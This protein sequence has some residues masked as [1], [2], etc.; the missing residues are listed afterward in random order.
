MSGRSR[1][2]ACAA[3]VIV[4]ILGLL[5]VL[6]SSAQAA[7]IHPLLVAERLS[8]ERTP[9]SVA[10]NQATHHFYVVNWNTSG[11][12]RRISNFEENGQIDAAS[13]ELTGAPA[14]NPQYVAVDNSGGA[15]QGFVYASDALE[16]VQQYDTTGAATAVTITE[17]DVPA[18]GTAQGGG[19]PSVV[20]TGSFRPR[21][22]AVGSAGDIFV[23]EAEAQAI[24]V[25][26]PTGSF[27]RQ[28][29]VGKA[30]AET[31]GIVV[32]A[33][34]NLYLADQT[35]AGLGEGLFELSGTSG[36]CIPVGCAPIDPAPVQ[37]VTVDNT[38]NKIYTT[39]SVGL[40][41]GK[42]SEY[43]LTTHALLGVT[44]VP[45]LHEPFGIGVQES[46]GEVIVADTRPSREGTIQIY[47]P[48]VVVP[49]VVTLPRPGSAT[50]KRP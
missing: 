16:T 44:R 39:G 2:R 4:G 50:T 24:D 19:L 29:A 14:F 38:G 27:V 5:A 20:N 33:A 32:D 15:T 31:T 49:D 7:R 8:E 1:K 42:F 43:D 25:F 28:V 10:V 36:E 34:G 23:A 48:V 12:E 35:S 37:G 17:A 45:A 47:G 11:Q 21:A 6:T 40:E 46:S 41:E 3:T 9:F 30:T 26:D 13:P 22:L 18:N